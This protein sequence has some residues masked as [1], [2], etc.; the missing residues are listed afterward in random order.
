MTAKGKIKVARRSFLAQSVARR[1]GAGPHRP[2]RPRRNEGAGWLN[3]WEAARE[4]AEERR[5]A[6]READTPKEEP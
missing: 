3:A 6:E 4:A 5:E 1:S 2:S